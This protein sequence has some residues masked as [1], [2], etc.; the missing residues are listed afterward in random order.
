[1]TR[2]NRERVELFSGQEVEV[3]R[4]ALNMDQ[5]EQYNPPPNPAKVT[6]SRAADYIARFGRTSWELDALEP[7]VLD[8]LISST[9]E[10]FVDQDLW[11]EV[12]AEELERRK[13]L[14]AMHGRF[15]EIAEFVRNLEGF[16]D[17]DVEERPE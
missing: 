1:M 5:V 6:D 16:D 4:I 12:K 10:Q 14:A 8:N 11:D 13:V 7:R 15:E 9:I 17:I 3:I 2:D